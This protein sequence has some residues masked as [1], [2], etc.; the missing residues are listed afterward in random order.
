MTIG[1]QQY[2]AVPLNSATGTGGYG[3]M[4]AES[5]PAMS[6][7]VNNQWPMGNPPQWNNEPV[8][9]GSSGMSFNNAY[10]STQLAANFAANG[11]AAH[12]SMPQQTIPMPSHQFHPGRRYAPST[13]SLAAEALP[14]EI[15]RAH[16][17][18]TF[19]WLSQH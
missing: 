8:F 1:G 9:A 5:S 13:S 11:M 10:G 19:W 6:M 4:P 17:A 7:P 2:V 16:L 18:D 15:C 3:L 12:A 14:H